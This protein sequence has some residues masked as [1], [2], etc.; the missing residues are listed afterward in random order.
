[1]FP[2]HFI[3]EQKALNYFQGKGSHSSLWIPSIFSLLLSRAQNTLL[4]VLFGFPGSSEG[5]ESSCNARDLSLIPGLGRSPGEGNGNPL[6]NSCLE[7]SHGQRS[8]AGYSPWGHKELDTTEQLHYY[9]LRAVLGIVNSGGLVTKS[10][11]AMATHSSILAWRIPMDREAWWATV[12]GVA[13]S[14]TLLS[15]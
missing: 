8:L 5:K 4:Q 7:N 10:E 6:Q 13:K 1:M 2:H 15:S 12:D 9:D 14:Q 3:M 11:K